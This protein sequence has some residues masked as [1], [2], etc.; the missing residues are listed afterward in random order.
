MC[1]TNNCDIFD[2][3]NNFPMWL[4]DPRS[5]Y[6]ISRLLYSTMALFPYYEYIKNVLI[7]MKKYSMEPFA[8]STPQNS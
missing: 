7:L 4:F 6:F 2:I 8:N 5:N 1:S 3:H